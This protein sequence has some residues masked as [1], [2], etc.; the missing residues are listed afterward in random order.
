MPDPIQI[1]GE[2]KDPLPP[3]PTPPEQSI[4]PPPG[5]T[6]PIKPAEFF[7]DPKLFE[8]S[9]VSANVSQNFIFTTE[10]KIRNY[11]HEYV[12]ANALRTNWLA[13]LGLAVSLGGAILTSNFKNVFGVT[14]AYWAAFFS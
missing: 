8:K 6:F 2:N 4:T 7:L 3:P 12:Q 9:T 11:L 5:G 13:P 1:P 14:A 10:D